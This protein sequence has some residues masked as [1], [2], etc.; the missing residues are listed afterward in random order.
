MRVDGKA[1]AGEIKTAL[2]GHIAGLSCPPVLAILEV[3]EDPV[4]GNFVRMKRAFGQAVGARVEHVRLDASSTEEAIIARVRELASDSEIDGIVVQLPLPE[5]VNAQAILDAVPVEKDIDVLARESVA[6]YASGLAPVLPPV[7]G[8]VLEILER[9]KVRL[10]GKDV[11]VVGAGRLVGAPVATILRHNHARV[12]VVDRPV[13]RLADMAREAHCI[14]LGVGRPGL[15]TPDMI[16]DGAIIIDAGTSESN[17]KVVGDADPACEARAS[18][19]TPVPGGVG[20]MTVAL[21]F[22]N[23]CVL[24]AHRRTP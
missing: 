17:G 8:A 14:V 1:I 3:G 10:F 20:P 4:I 7:A 2:A 9:N 23:L 6:R 16:R 11:L 5:G 24:A 19:F 15:L 18:L 13:E 12:T 22:K 21:I